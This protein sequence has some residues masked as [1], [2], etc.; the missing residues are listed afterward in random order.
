MKAKYQ[1]KPPRKL[2]SFQKADTNNLKSKVLNFTQVFLNSNPIK[3]SVHTNWEIIQHDLCTIM[4]TTVQWKLSHGKRHLPW[5]SL[6]IKRS[7]RRRDKLHSRARNYQDVVHWD[8]FRQCRDKVARMLQRAYHNY[9]NHTNG[10]SLTEQPRSF[11]SCVKLMR[12]E[13]IGIPT[14]R[15]QTKLCA[16]D[17]EKACTLNEQ[18]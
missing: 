7:V 3:N 14:L 1:T 9:I 5:I 6:R 11:W 10:D 4:D 18:L 16:T 8:H 12:T 15:T 13:N 17:K 2:L